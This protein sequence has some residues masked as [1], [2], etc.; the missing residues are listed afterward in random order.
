M[1]T[2]YEKRIR[3]NRERYRNDPEFRELRKRKSREYLSKILADPELRKKY[4]EKQKKYRNEHPEI[5]SKRQ[6]KTKVGYLCECGTIDKTTNRSRF[7]PKN[8]AEK[9]KCPS[10]GEYTEKRRVIYNRTTGEISAD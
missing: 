7:N 3:R 10:C 8:K 4:Y 5:Y 1:P 2:E 9:N 6:R